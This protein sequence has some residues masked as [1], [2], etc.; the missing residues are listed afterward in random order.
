M[1]IVG[2]FPKDKPM[3]KDPTL[4]RCIYLIEKKILLML[5]YPG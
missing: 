2:I 5:R 3:S 4:Y 1:E